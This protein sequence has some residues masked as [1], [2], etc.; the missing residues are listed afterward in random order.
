MSITGCESFKS[1]GEVRKRFFISIFYDPEISSPANLHTTSA[2]ALLPSM[3]ESR[4]KLPGTFLR[5]FL[6]M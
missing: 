6:H 3:G 4:P 2:I 1:F 5:A